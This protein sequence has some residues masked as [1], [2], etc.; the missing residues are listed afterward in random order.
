MSS[1]LEG[2]ISDLFVYFQTP[3]P[4]DS[5]LLW[6]IVHLWSNAGI[7]THNELNVRLQP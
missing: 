1:I 2:A 5:K 7:Q 4:F 3:I 6:K